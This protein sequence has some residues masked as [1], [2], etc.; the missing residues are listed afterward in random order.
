MGVEEPWRLTQRSIKQTIEDCI[1][2]EF[3][4]TYKTRPWPKLEVPPMRRPQL[5]ILILFAAGLVAAGWIIW[6]SGYIQVEYFILLGLTIPIL[7]FLK[8]RFV[9][10]VGLL[11]FQVIL[12]FVFIG[13]SDYALIAVAALIGA[14]IAFESPIIMY[15]IL[16][17]AVWYDMTPFAFTHTA[18]IEFIVGIALLVGWIFREVLRPQQEKSI[19][20]FPEKW[21][22]ISFLVW[23]AIGFALWCAQP[24]PYGWYQLKLIIIGTVF[25]LITPM[26]L[27]SERDIDLIVFTWILVGIIAS[28]STVLGP[29]FGYQPE[30][31]GWGAALG[32]MGVQKNLS[33]SFMSFSFFIA[34]AYFYWTKGLFRKLVSSIIM[35]GILGA[36]LYQQSR[37]AAVGLLIGFSLFWLADAFGGRGKQQTLRFLAQ[38]FLFVSILS[39]VLILIYFVGLGQMLG[40]YAELLYTPTEI[41]TSEVRKVL[42]DT[43]FEMAENE[44]HPLRGLGV[45]AFWVLGAEKYELGTLVGVADS[46]DELIQQGINP[47]NLY[48]DT[49]L[50][51]GVIGIALFGLLAIV[52]LSKL[53]RGF[54]GFQSRKY[55]YLCLGLFCG[56]IAFYFHCIFDFTVFIIGRFWLYVG[57]AIAVINLGDI[58]RTYQQNQIEV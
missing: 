50:H 11:C 15:M 26:L 47:H 24:F 10:I 51:Y 39:I 58:L 45:G 29:F 5:I 16:I 25:F 48:I 52:I 42:W 40:S 43:A 34:L 36:T 31:T 49:F 57:L 1:M 3:L 53:W 18:R 38:F 9:T 21:I 22:V 32:A 37:S 23:A 7:F 46:P 27:R 14:I 8:N 41:G 33:A 28:A 4:K 35:L 13:N 19:V 2:M 44:G 30:I 17:A 56:L 55:K 12:A 54:R 6:F 20:H